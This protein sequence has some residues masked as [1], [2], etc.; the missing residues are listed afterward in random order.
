MRCYKKIFKITLLEELQYKGSY[1]S[2]VICQ[3]AFG[4]IYILL[5]SAFFKSGVPQNFGQQQMVNYIWLGQA[6][7]A[8]FYYGDNC[9]QRITKDII[10]GNVSYQLIKPV[11]IYDYWFGYVMFTSVSKAIVRCVPLLIIAS[12]LP[13]GYSLTLPTSFNAFLVSVLAL[14]LGCVLV[15]AIKMIAYLFTLYTL[16]PRGIFYVTYTVFAFLGGGGIPIPLM[17]NWLQTILNFLP[18]RYASDL[19]YRL[20]IGNINIIQGIIQILIQIAWII[21]LIVII[22]LLLTKKCK[23]LAIQ[24]G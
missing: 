20:Y 7:F 12:L 11:N 24:G 1:I 3:V 6:F 19:P 21:G 10:T 14:V 4:F 17:P 18:F 22:R 23:R 13:K 5:Y 9:K 2:G 15:S 16:D 8:M